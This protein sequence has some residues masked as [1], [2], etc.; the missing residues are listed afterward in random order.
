MFF[1]K[2]I[3]VQQKLVP[4]FMIV[5][6][7]MSITQCINIVKVYSIVLSMDENIG[8]YDISIFEFYG[9][10]KNINK[11][12]VDILTKISIKWKLFKRNAFLYKNTKINK[13]IHVK[14]VLLSIMDDNTYYFQK[15]NLKFLNYI[16][17]YLLL[18]DQLS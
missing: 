14:V 8:I 9:Y 2:C 3:F 12:S 10:I 13:N 15:I 5:L 1:L 17:I 18:N 11:I 7:F 16:Y 4:D 6:Q